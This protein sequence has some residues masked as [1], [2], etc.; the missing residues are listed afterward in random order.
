M[1]EKKAKENDI[2]S[3]HY[4]GTLEDGKV[5]DSSEGKSPLQF[6]IGEHRLIKGFEKGVVG[7]SINEEKTLTI[8][9]EDGYGSRNE[10]LQQ[11]IPISALNIKEKPKP[12]TILTL[13]DKEGKMAMAFVKKVDK[14]NMTLDLNHPLAGKTLSF[15]I[16]LVEIK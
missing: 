14:D 9:P 15:K 11:E 12:G 16:K 4:T 10:A 1:A 3:I 7:M 13:K 8:K 5:F 2:V 6:K